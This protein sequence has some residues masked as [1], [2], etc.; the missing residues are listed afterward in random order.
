MRFHY[1]YRKQLNFAVLPALV[2]PALLAAPSAQ[3]ELSLGLGMASYLDPY[4]GQETEHLAAP[5]IAYSGDRFNFQFTTLSY[6]L[7]T[8]A[9]VEVSLL[10][11]ARIQGY[12]A[13][14]SPYLVGMDARDGS[15]D[16]GIGLDWNGFNLS[17]TTDWLGK[18]KGHEASLTYTNGY[19]LGKLQLLTSVGFNWQSRALTNYYYGVR[20]A[21]AREFM[22][23]DQLFERAAY[24]ADDATFPKIGFLAKYSLAGSW[25]LIG[26]AEIQFLPDAITLSPIVGKDETWGAFL[27]VARDF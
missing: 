3:A 4:K 8:V 20:S 16:G 15:L 22:I 14:D 18:H 11:A 27:G 21:E 17:L 26:G 24:N 7:L 2:L 19:D 1:P 25:F 5:L 13:S 23:D 9:D 6:R 10:A 12:E